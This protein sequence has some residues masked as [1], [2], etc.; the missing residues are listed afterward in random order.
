MEFMRPHLKNVNVYQPGKPIEEVQRELGLETV[1]K[2]AS[3]ENPLGPS[4]KAVQAMRNCAAI[5]HR[6]P[7]ASCHYLRQDLARKMGVAENSLI[8]GNGSDEVIGF[9]MRAFVAPGQ[10]ILVGSPTFMIYEIQAKAL[11]LGVVVSPM[12]NYRYDLDDILARITSRTRLVFIANPDNPN[13]TYIDHATMESFLKKLPEH[14]LVFMDEA[15]CEFAPEDFP[16]TVELFKAGYNI[17]ISRTFSKA[18]GLAGLR[19][20]YACARPELINAMERVREP[21]NVNLIVQEAARAA[22]GD[23][24]HLHKVLAITEREK[25]WLYRQLKKLKVHYVPS[26]TNFILMDIKRDATAV[27]DSLLKDG[28]I[29]RNM[30]GWGYATHIR[31]TPGTRKQNRAFIASLQKALSV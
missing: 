17:I 21:F 30:K 11:D 27:C 31:V 12:K 20:G 3:N 1:Y 9:P 29:V 23:T 13:G 6:Y 28:I 16:R 7:D 10:E 24:E 15:Y 25:S 5:V 18:Y 2:L 19:L 14:V 8:F 22:L 26:A 4:K